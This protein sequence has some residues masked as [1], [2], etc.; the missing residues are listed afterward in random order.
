MNKEM[1]DVTI[2]IPTRT[3]VSHISAA[4][5]S[6]REKPQ[7][8]DC[9]IIVGADN[10]SKEV[11]E[12]LVLF[13][14]KYNF[15]WHIYLPPAGGDRLGIVGMVEDLVSLVKTEFVYYMHDDMIIGNHTL[16]NLTRA[17]EEKTVLS[18]L[19]IEPPIY[20]ES[21]EKVLLPLG[22][23]PE[24][25]NNEEFLKA[26]QGIIEQTEM[27]VV[28]GFFAP[29]FFKKTD[30][31]GYDPVFS[32][33]SRED[34][35]LALRFMDAGCR[36]F[37]VWAS[38]VYH[39][40]GKGS[41]RKDGQTD[42]PEWKASNMKNQYNYLR[43]YR[44]LAHTEYVLPLRAPD[45]PISAHILV[46]NDTDL[47]YGFIAHIEPYFNELV[48][49]LDEGQPKEIVQKNWDEIHRY[50]ADQE[51]ITPTN[52][53]RSVFKIFYR[54]L[55]G[56]FAAQTNFAIDQCSHDWVIKLDVDEVFPG[57]MLNNLRF[58]MKEL[59][60]ANP[61]LTVIGFPRMN[62]LDGKVSNDIPREHWFTPEF[63]RY[64]M[65]SKNVQNPDI[66]FRLTRHEKWVGKVHEVPESLA[67]QDQDR[68]IVVPALNF[69]HPKS[70][71]KQR[72][73]EELYGM[74]NKPVVKP[75]TDIKKLVY[76]SVIYTVEG[77][78]EHA[79]Q[80]I[81]QFKKDG[82]DIFLLDN[83]Y[84][85]QFGEYLKDCYDPINVREDEYVT[86]INQPPVRWQ[87][88]V[89]YKNPIGYLAFEGQLNKEWTKLIN[90]SPIKELW[91][92]STYCKTMF[93]KSGVNKSIAVIP[94]GIDPTVWKKKKV[95]DKDILQVK[96]DGT[97]VF[98][99]IGTYQNNRK[100]FDLLVKAFSE[101]FGKDENVKLVIKVNKIYSPNES[102]ANYCLPHINKDGNTNIEFIDLD[103]SE[104]S[105]ID[106]FNTVDCFV[107]PHRAEGFGINILNA[108]AVELPVIATGSTGNMD[109]CTK[110][111]CYLIDVD[112]ED[113]WAD[114]QPPY[115][116]AKWS[117]PSIVSLK[118]QMRKVFNNPEIARK[119]A[120]TAAKE[121]HASWTWAHTVEKM[122][123]RIKELF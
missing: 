85:P 57:A 40:S 76:D 34:S 60:T 92:P 91:T 93:E 46:G 49:V 112:R 13:A 45:I 4:I 9:K 10:P 77:I 66:Q 103:L 121:V 35:D 41:R 95:T 113:V 87:R 36:L 11:E 81:K 89:G 48:F 18:S 120:K 90:E 31:V 62:F 101:E 28:E 1:K 108:M 15:D 115:E 44:T 33:Q 53:D 119:K 71:E 42:H 37:T 39:F 84:N 109:F 3:N 14:T 51:A 75:K 116:R 2:I 64:P 123:K 6:I 17:W 122:K 27:K 59:L 23:E 61:N 72:R 94:H 96:Q 7:Y 54:R 82:Y 56:D 102:F 26:E 20:P 47:L 88:S 16:N 19:R 110:D 55:D 24:S 106:L 5:N 83:N 70:R 99:A 63:D 78:T 118:R 104:E 86:I 98:F 97:F 68:I 22:T 80:E 21:V 74:I 73:Q 117:R 107:S 29:H 52:F 58:A 100:G 105:L 25:F 50:I 43:K 111:N 8:D 12:W 38:I 69:Q 65:E 79:R 32:P 114:F 30:W 67:R